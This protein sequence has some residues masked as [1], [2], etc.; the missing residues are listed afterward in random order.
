MYSH[1]NVAHY[2]EKHINRVV[3][4]KISIF[5]HATLP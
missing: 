1:N 3:K 4:M 5:L 2:G